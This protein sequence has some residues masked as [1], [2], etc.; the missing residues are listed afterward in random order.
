[1]TTQV[2]NDKKG[3]NLSSPG[4]D[5]SHLSNAYSN[6]ER[7]QLRSKESLTTAASLI[8]SRL[9]MQRIGQQFLQ[10]PSEDG[11]VRIRHSARAAGSPTSRGGQVIRLA[12]PPGLR[13]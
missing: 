9:D 7:E 2:R 6:H 3:E 10:L 4:L 5:A 13:L 1:M 8:T 11:E 12:A